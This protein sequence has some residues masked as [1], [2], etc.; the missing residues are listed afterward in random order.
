MIFKCP[1]REFQNGRMDKM[2]K[3]W[4]KEKRERE[5]ETYVYTKLCTVNSYSSSS[6]NCQKLET[7]K[8][9]S[10]SKCS[11][12]GVC[13][14]WAL[15]SAGRDQL[16]KHTRPRVDL[17][18]INAEYRKQVLPVPSYTVLF[19]QQSQK[20]SCRNGLHIQGAGREGPSRGWLWRESARNVRWGSLLNPG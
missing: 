8:C 10:R 1:R 7:S 2:I 19:L 4:E 15:L 9:P 6:H 18:G 13:V 11:R 17:K 16:C 3:F 12:S 5:M 14:Q 20:G